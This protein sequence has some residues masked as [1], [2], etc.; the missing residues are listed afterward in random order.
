MKPLW[1]E[2][3]TKIVGYYPPPPEG[4]AL[5]MLVDECCI[6]IENLFTAFTTPSGQPRLH[7][8]LRR[9]QGQHSKLLVDGLRYWQDLGDRN[10]TGHNG[11]RSWI[12]A[13]TLRSQDEVMSVMNAFHK[14]MM[15]KLRMRKV[16]PDW[17]LD[18][19]AMIVLGS[20]FGLDAPKTFAELIAKRAADK[21]EQERKRAEAIERR[22]LYELTPEYAEEQRLAKIN[23]AKYEAARWKDKLLDNVL[24]VLEPYT[25]IKVPGQPTNEERL[26]ASIVRER[27]K[28]IKRALRPVFEKTDGLPSFDDPQNLAQG[29]SGLHGSIR[30]FDGRTS[31]A[32]RTLRTLRSESHHADI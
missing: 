15:A 17:V 31:G 30:E 22:R 26:D 19:D 21:A 7:S 12:V 16:E 1:N 14:D 29:R 25:P 8:D 28:Y 5:D 24:D 9:S 27:R 2:D 4:E 10:I 32:G 13:G 18:N 23:Q 3:K 20:R 6:A 11:V